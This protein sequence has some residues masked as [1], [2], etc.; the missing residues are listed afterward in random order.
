[1]SESLNC[2][3]II[4]DQIN[5][6]LADLA[7]EA[8]EAEIDLG[9]GAI[10][11]LSRFGELAPDFTYLFALALT[12]PLTSDARKRHRQDAGWQED[13]EMRNVPPEELREF[14]SAL[15]SRKVEQ[16]LRFI[17]VADSIEIA[18][19]EIPLTTYVPEGLQ[20]RFAK[21]RPAVWMRIFSHLHDLTTIHGMVRPRSIKIMLLPHENFKPV[22]GNC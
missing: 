3:Q 14:S 18:D 22:Q 16:A 10:E 19:E 12:P 13:I 11:C 17:S 9:E 2:D 21:C 8:A 4:I 6:I 5:E 20:N 1:M 15:K 7:L